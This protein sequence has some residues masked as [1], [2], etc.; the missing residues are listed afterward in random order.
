[1]VESELRAGA[2]LDLGDW[3]RFDIGGGETLSGGT[4]GTRYPVTAWIGATPWATFNIDLVWTGVR[5]TGVPDHVPS[6]GQSRCPESTSRDTGPI[7]R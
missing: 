7:P 2:E 4:G 1:M 3:F 6:V 5:M